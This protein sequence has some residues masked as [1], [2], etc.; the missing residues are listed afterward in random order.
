ML[1]NYNRTVLGHRT[2]RI[3]TI[4]TKIDRTRF[5]FLRF[6]RKEHG[7]HPDIMLRGL[8]HPLQCTPRIHYPTKL[9]P[10]CIGTLVH[11]RLDS[12]STDRL[13]IKGKPHTCAYMAVES[14]ETF[15]AF[16]YWNNTIDL[17][18]RSSCFIVW[19]SALHVE[20]VNASEPSW[21]NTCSS[22][23]ALSKVLTRLK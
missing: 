22:R 1:E 18:L 13:Q 10:G 2:S 9:L 4:Y 19:R 11:L 12:C 16:T 15:V 20:A 17:N 3:N 23:F 6:F 5:C 14:S 8:G 7:Y 21:A